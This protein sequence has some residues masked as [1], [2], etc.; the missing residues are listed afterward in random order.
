MGPPKG[1]LMKKK[2][3]KEKNKFSKCECNR[4]VYVCGFRIRAD[5]GRGCPLKGPK[6]APNTKV[7]LTYWCMVS[8]ERSWRV[9]HDAP[10]PDDVTS[11]YV[12]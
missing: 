2:E 12:N 7:V 10:I 3:N 1:H 11:G 4:F 6:W 9:L 8:I 5:P